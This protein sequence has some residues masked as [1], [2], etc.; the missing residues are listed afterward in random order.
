[1]LMK[2]M[3]GKWLL[4]LFS[5]WATISSAQTITVKTSDTLRALGQK[6]AT[7]Y[8]AGHAP[9]KIETT[10]D[11]TA[12]VFAAFAARKADVVITSR[13]IRFKEVQA[14]EQ[15]FGQRPTEFRVG[16]IGA[17]VYVHADNPV[18]TLMYEEL[19]AIYLGKRRNWKQVG[20]QDAAM[21]VYGV[22]TN[23]LAGELFVAEVLMG[24]MVTNDVRLV[25]ATELATTLARDVNA[26]GFGDFAALPGLR[27]VKVKRAY[28]STPVEPS[29]EA[30]GNRIYPITQFV[31]AYVSPEANKGE[32]KSFVDWL[33]SDEG[34]Q[35]A[36]A[37]GYFAVA[38]KWRTP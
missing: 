11:G 17:A 32:I 26:I 31:Y 5:A 1:M 38:A 35:T 7:T 36:V 37:T 10:G 16:V 18:T 34:Q 6:W 23:T 20:G 25:T 30:I 24:K 3:F 9:T 19:E 12:E 4:L 27:A 2:R 22:S 13:K 29:A 28:S 15:A 33:R 8:G 14:C 21:T